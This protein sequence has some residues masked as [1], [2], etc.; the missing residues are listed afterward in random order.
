MALLAFSGK[1]WDAAQ[2]RLDSK[3]F[4]NLKRQEELERAQAEAGGHDTSNTPTQRSGTS[5]SWESLLGTVVVCG[6]RQHGSHA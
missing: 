6:G 5:E 3:T 1:L 2:R 4:E